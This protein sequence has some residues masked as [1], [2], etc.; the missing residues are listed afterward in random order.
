MLCN[1]RF[2]IDKVICQNIVDDTRA[3]S[4]TRKRGQVHA[5]KFEDL[6]RDKRKV[7]RDVFRYV[8]I[9]IRVGAVNNLF[10]HVFG[11]I[12]ACPSLTLFWVDDRSV[13][14]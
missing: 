1:R 9:A 8:A 4:K 13:S 11:P 3:L 14:V 2:T 6:V 5:L 12:P 7:V 10:L